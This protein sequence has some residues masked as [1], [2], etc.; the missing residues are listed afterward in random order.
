MK[1]GNL[2]AMLHAQTGIDTTEIALKARRLREAG[3]FVKETRS[4]QSPRAT[5]R[6]VAHL[7]MMILA[8]APAL[9]AERTIERADRL[10]NSDT[11]SANKNQEAGPNFDIFKREGTSFVDAIEW[12]LAEAAANPDWF[13]FAFSQTWLEFEPLSFRG[14]LYLEVLDRAPMGGKRIFES[15]LHFFDPSNELT[16]SAPKAFSRT[17]RIEAP[18]L[19]ALGAEF[20]RRDG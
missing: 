10:L 20:A 12:L 7:I 15:V 19:Q 14:C 13:G 3:L 2:I 9:Y 16:N 5:H 1:V 8:D 11:R 17:T 6:H 4:P 18:M